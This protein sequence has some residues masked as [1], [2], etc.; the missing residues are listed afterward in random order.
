MHHISIKPQIIFI[1]NA[2]NYFILALILNNI[3]KNI[4]NLTINKRF[5]PYFYYQL[6]L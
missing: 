6:V 1:N 3:V 4:I 5:T 2:V